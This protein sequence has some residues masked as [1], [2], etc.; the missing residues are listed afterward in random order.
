MKKSGLIVVGLLMVMGCKSLKPVA[1][2]NAIDTSLRSRALQNH[3]EDNALQYQSLQ[4][5][6]QALIERE[7]KRQKIS[8]TLRLKKD[9]GI[10]VSGSV[11]IP[12][13]L[14][15]ITP[16]QLQ[17]YEKLNR[18]YAQI[19][20]GQVKNLIGAQ[21]DYKMVEH[22]ITAS[23]LDKRALKRAKITFT[24][25]TYVLSSKKRRVSLI[26]EYDA[27]FRLISQQ[28]SNDKTTVRIDYNDYKLIDN[29]WIPEQLSAT[30][31]G[32]DK[33]TKLKLQSKQTQ[34]NR[35]FKMPFEIPKGYA[36]IKLP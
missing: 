28:I 5:R 24:Q 30:L 34:L 14:A 23:P 7:G 26:W 6:G 22:I 1:T 32:A 11:I 16:K 33:S 15:F 19:D 13:A 10:W 18:Q 20:Y 4:W 27:A 2:T 9:E 17:F 3:I 31:L 29:Q 8:V 21:V 35:K 12:L 25:N 36:K